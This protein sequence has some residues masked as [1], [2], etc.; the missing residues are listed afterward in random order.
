MRTGIIILAAGGSTRM[1]QPKML[2]T[3]GGKTLLQRV[4]EQAL[5]ATTAPVVVVTGAGHDLV[6]QTLQHQAAYFVHNEQWQEGMGVSIRTGVGKITEIDKALDA[7]IILVCDQP[8]ITTAL[9]QQMMQQQS[10]TGK[11]LV[12]CAY[13]NTIGTPVLFSKIYFAQLL[14]LHGKEGAKSILKQSAEDI[15]VVDF[16]QGATDID[17]PGDYERLLNANTGTSSPEPEA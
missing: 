15:A 5:G 11:G 7:V 8:F 2:L 10:E 3:Y 12:A 1:G 17:T 13:S 14:T 4:A 6:Q 16:P 9:L